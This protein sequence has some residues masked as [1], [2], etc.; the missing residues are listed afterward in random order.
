MLQQLSQHGG[1][2]KL[3]NLSPVYL[4]FTLC[5]SR[6]RRQVDWLTLGLHAQ[7]VGH[8]CHQ[9][10]VHDPVLREVPQNKTRSD[11]AAPL[12]NQSC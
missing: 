10:Q 2:G 11:C 9:D 8:S 3:S 7:E 12:I 1:I 6:V 4:F 5:L